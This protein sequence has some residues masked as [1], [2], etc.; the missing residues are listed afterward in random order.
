[1]GE[2]RNIKFGINVIDFGKSHLTNDKIPPKGA[3]M[4]RVLGAE[5]LNF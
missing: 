4:V 1:M 5:F 3:G 2:A